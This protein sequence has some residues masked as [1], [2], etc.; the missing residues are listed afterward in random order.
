MCLSRL[1]SRRI[2]RGDH[3][4]T[5]FVSARTYNLEKYSVSRVCNVERSRR[6]SPR[7]VWGGNGQTHSAMFGLDQIS[8]TGWWRPRQ[9][10]G[11][12]QPAFCLLPCK[13]PWLVSDGMR[14][15]GRC[16]RSCWLDL[17]SPEWTFQALPKRKVGLRTKQRKEPRLTGHRSFQSKAKLALLFLYVLVFFFFFQR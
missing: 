3:M 10:M 12:E 13:T 8:C 1:H 7:W 17:P 16:W 6:A 11:F 4:T 2:C 5:F 15:G 14:E 9:G